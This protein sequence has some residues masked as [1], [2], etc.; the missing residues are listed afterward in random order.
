MIGLEFSNLNRMVNTL[1][2]Y[3]KG[4]ESLVPLWELFGKEFYAQETKLF[5]DAPWEPLSPRYAEQKQKEFGGKP[6]LR[7]T[8]DLFKSL[9]QQGAPGNIH[10]I[11]PLGAVFGSSDFKVGFHQSGTAIMPARPPLAEPDLDR[12][13]TIAGRY[14]A[15]FIEK[16]AA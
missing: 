1:G 15:E 3:E 16:A 5:S 2:R 8:D 4:L 13:E 7:A 12:Y 14:V 9:T 6:L 10:D 11:R